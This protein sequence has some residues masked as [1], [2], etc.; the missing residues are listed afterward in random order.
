VR[1]AGSRRSRCATRTLILGS[2]A[3][4]LL[5][6]VPLASAH[7]TRP[8]DGTNARESSLPSDRAPVPAHARDATLAPDRLVTLT[9]A[10]EPRD[11][12]ALT[13]LDASLGANGDSRFLTESQFEARFSPS[14]GNVSKVLGYF[15]GFGAREIR[16]TSDRLGLTFELPAG[17]A[18]SALGIDWS[19]YA[20]APSGAPVYT[21]TADP[22]LPAALAPMVAGIGG[23]TN[24]FNARLSASARTFAAH[25]PVARLG[26]RPT[27]FVRDAS[28]GEFLYLGSDYAQAYGETRLFPGYGSIAGAT[29]PT[30][31]AVAT[32]LMSGYNATANVDLPPWD[33]AVILAYF[34]D[35][36]PSNWPHPTLLGV[37]VS[38]GGR[39]PPPPGSFGTRADD[40]ANEAENSLDLEMAG[41]TAPGARLANFY[42]AG[43][44]DASPTSNLTVGDLADGFATALGAALAYNYSPQRLA[45]VTNSYGLPDLNDPLWNTELAHAAAL[46]VTVL[47]S[48]GDQGDAPDRLSGRFQGP[49]P[50]WP[51]SAAFAGS[52]A[53]AVGGT[54]LVLEGRPTGTF[55]G[56]NLNDPFD[57]SVRGIAQQSAYWDTSGGPGNF[58][59]S[60]GGASVVYSE[61]AW[62]MHS[63][64]QP[65]IVN[66]TVTQRL[67]RLDRAEPDVAFAANSTIAYISANS[68]GIFFD[69][70]G[71]TSVASPL[72]AG[73][74]AEWTAVL[75]SPLGFVDPALYRMASFYAAHPS[76]TSP[77]EDVVSGS[78]YLFSA[79][80]GWDAVTGWGGINASKF[81]AAYS[82]ASIRN[83]TYTG[84]TPGLPPGGTGAASR[85]APPPIFLILILIVA[86]VIALVIAYVI[87][88]LN[89]RVAPSPYYAPVQPYFV[90]PGAYYAP[91]TAPTWAYPPPPA[92]GGTPAVAPEAATGP[93]ERLCPTCGRV[94]TAGPYYCPYCGAPP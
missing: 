13:S 82:N 40:T 88:R 83:Y 24:A 1:T 60:E 30:G 34:N 68:S 18:A 52:G 57:S 7:S 33:P 43:S 8:P 38:F 10:L 25:V 61:P 89:R 37:P 50:T 44:L 14:D 94:R 87:S 29:F 70:L 81:V 66:A 42:I 91:P 11:A 84:P 67:G 12:T 76:A 90:P 22:R 92:A 28:S 71:G 72:L 27:E 49:W 59:G 77:F 32:I 79:G 39:T 73:F 35:T 75:G 63:A 26:A 6:G 41:S 80:P 64:A 78:N 3:L 15:A 36:F 54:S 93:G 17:R 47:A 2:L 9:V 65:M 31:E 55:A 46:G 74:V 51:A 23:L 20:T 85:S 56:G 19:V 5:A 45:A 62:Q 48:S 16:V 53:V 58:S 86:I 21:A 69:V 4:L